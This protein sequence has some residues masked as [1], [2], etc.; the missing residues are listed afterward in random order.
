[1]PSYSSGSPGSPIIH[2]QSPHPPPK[3]AWESIGM[4]GMLAVQFCVLALIAW[5]LVGPTESSGTAD[6]IAKLEKTLEAREDTARL[7]ERSQR[8]LDVMDRIV[9]EMRDTSKGFVERY[10]EEIQRSQDME[11]ALQNSQ[12]MQKVIED[13]SRQTVQNFRAELEK[14]KAS[15][16]KLDTALTDLKEERTKLKDE[17][18]ASEKQVASLKK[19][20][21]PDE[22]DKETA[23]TAIFVW[24]PT[25]RTWMVAGI[26]LA[27]IGLLGAAAYFFRAQGMPPLDEPL[28]EDPP[29]TRREEFRVQEPSPG[30][31]PPVASNPD[32][33]A[34][35][36]AAR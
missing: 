18:K 23:A 16:E 29:R 8:D 35:T 33:P 11:K 28:G 3:P 6:A 1:M 30:E 26:G 10:R 34:S 7:A 12:A 21:N 27:A 13:S 5:K 24:P 20:L 25:Q 22:D 19:Q 17:L 14:Q 4:L 9:G 15:L 32:A 31:K 2:V 36:E